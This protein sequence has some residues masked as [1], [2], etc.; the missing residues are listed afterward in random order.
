MLA[1]LYTSSRETSNSETDVGPRRTC[2]CAW[3]ACG[4]RQRDDGLRRRDTLRTASAEELGEHVEGIGI[5]V[6]ATLVCLEAF[7]AMP[8]VYLSFLHLK[9]RTGFHLGLFDTSDTYG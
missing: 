5:L 8:V 4:I 6:L 1:P 9:I 2:S 3:T 7:F